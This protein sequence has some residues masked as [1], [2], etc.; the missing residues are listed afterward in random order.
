MTISVETAGLS[1]LVFAGGT[2]HGAIHRAGVFA[3][4]AAT[5]AGSVPRE[6]AV[7]VAAALLIG[8]GVTEGV[9]VGEHSGAAV[10]SFAGLRCSEE[11]RFRRQAVDVLAQLAEHVSAQ[12]HA[13]PFGVLR[14]LLD[15]KPLPVRIKPR[16]DLPGDPRYGDNPGIPVNVLDSQLNELTPTQPSLD[17]GFDEQLQL[18]GRQVCVNQLELLGR[19][20]APTFAG[21]SGGFDSHTG[22][23]KRDLVVQRSRENGAQDRHRVTDRV[24]L[25]AFPLQAEDPFTDVGGQDVDQSVASERRHD[26]AVEAVAVTLPGGEFDDVVRKPHLLHIVLE[27]LPAALKILPTTFAGPGGSSLPRAV[28]FL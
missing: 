2:P 26:V 7:P 4:A 13:A 1:W 25:H 17:I 12:G 23:E 21:D 20:D 22:M 18:A 27:P 19:D 16:H 11:Q 28:G 24:R 9:G 6:R 15:E 5:F 10:W 14:I 3:V 8:F